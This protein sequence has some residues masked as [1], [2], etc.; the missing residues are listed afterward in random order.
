MNVKRRD[1]LGSD[2]EYV[3]GKAPVI[4]ALKAKKR[5]LTTLYVQEN[6]FTDLEMY[7]NRGKLSPDADRRILAQLRDDW[8]GDVTS[9]SKMRLNEMTNNAVHQGLVLKAS[10]LT[11]PH[12]QC[13]P[14]PQ[15]RENATEKN[16]VWLAMDEIVDPQN[17]GNLLRTACFVGVEGVL[18]T[19]KNS[20]PLS[21]TCSKAS[22]GALETM[23]NVFGTNNLPRTLAEA[24]QNGWRVV[25][26][27]A[28]ANAGTV[29]SLS[30]IER[31]P[32]TVVVLGSESR[33]LRTNV[34]RS[35][36]DGFVT[37]DRDPNMRA[38]MRRSLDSLNVS[39]AGGIILHHFTI[40]EDI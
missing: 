9:A 27:D 7:K 40:R 3:F 24:S 35:C 10:R 12:I 23:N 28:D 39:V 26:A 2:E 31:G 29:T 14:A 33:G 17:L 11:V 6:L 20:A 13:I 19:V 18:L 36:A 16:Q 38:D 4:A 15:S 34:K 8:T 32:P 25:G 21:A 30:A 5:N 1:D 22:A 37:I